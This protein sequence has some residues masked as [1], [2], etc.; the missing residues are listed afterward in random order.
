MQYIH[1]HI[2]IYYTYCV[3]WK[4]INVDG[5]GISR[6]IPCCESAIISLCCSVLQC[7]VVCCTELQSVVACCES[8]IISL[9]CSVLQCAAVYCSVLQCVAECCSV[10]RVS[11]QRFTHLNIH[12]CVLGCFEETQ[13]C[14]EEIQGSFAKM[15]GFFEKVQ[16]SLMGKC[17]F[18]SNTTFLMYIYIQHL[19]LVI[20]S[21]Y[22]YF[23]FGGT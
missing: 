17:V 15:Q 6:E 18:P 12:L 16:G 1:I 20:V 23:V 3:C 8:A 5:K 11:N 22:F 10:F 7:V 21:I 19:S 14:F 4:M 9:C 2:C 13:G